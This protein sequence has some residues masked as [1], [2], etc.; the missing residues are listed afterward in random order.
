MA[1]IDMTH[2][3][4]GGRMP[5]TSAGSSYKLRKRVDFSEVLEEKGS[6]LAASDI[7]QVLDLPVKMA[8]M[9]ANIHPVEAADADTLTLDLGFIST[10]EADPDNFVDGFDATQISTDGVPIFSVQGYITTAT[11]LDLTLQTLTGT[12]TKGKVDVVAWV[13]DLV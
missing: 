11:T 13:V 3:S 5:G 12:L 4:S 9:A 10:P 6:A 7:V 2:G 1:T 8:V